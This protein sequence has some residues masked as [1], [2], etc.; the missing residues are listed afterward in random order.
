MPY[1]TNSYLAEAP[2]VGQ[3]V[4]YRVHPPP[5]GGRPEEGEPG[6]ERVVDIRQGELGV[7]GRHD[8][9][10]DEAHV[11]VGWLGV[12]PV[13]GSVEGKE[14]FLLFFYIYLK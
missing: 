10:R 4:S 5:V 12:A 14:F 2:V 1:D 7:G 8:S 6:P 9:L 13:G 11:R 3:V